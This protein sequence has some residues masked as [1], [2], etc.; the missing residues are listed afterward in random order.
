MNAPLPYRAPPALPQDPCAAFPADRQV[1]FAVA[2]L[3]QSLDGR[4]ATPTGASRYINRPAALAHLHRLRAR[5]DAVVIGVGTAVADNPRLTVRHVEGKS[6]ARVI[7]D[8]R[9]RLPAGLQ[10][11]NDDGARRIVVRGEEAADCPGAE[12]LRLPLKDGAFDPNELRRALAATGLRQILVEGG[13]AT[14]SAFIA[15]GALDRLHVL[16]GPLILG[17]GFTGLNLPPIA[18]VDE[19]LAPQTSVYLLADGDVLFDCDLS[20][21]REGHEDGETHGSRSG[22]S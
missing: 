16:V 14:V 12:T 9:G 3:G 7:I 20:R 5:L 11:L 10:V 8:P 21:R 19:A 1:S 4:I 6:P 18:T 13:A 17:S 22:A 2:Q 15:A